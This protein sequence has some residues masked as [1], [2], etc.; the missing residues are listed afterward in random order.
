MMTTEEDLH[1]G[2]VLSG[3]QVRTDTGL[4]IRLG[5]VRTERWRYSHS[6]YVWFGG[7]ACAR[8]SSIVN[9]TAAAADPVDC[10]PDKYY[11]KVEARVDELMYYY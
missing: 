1:V 10:I 7:G 4:D 5:K 2:R 6:I 3:F 11:G 8:K 9:V